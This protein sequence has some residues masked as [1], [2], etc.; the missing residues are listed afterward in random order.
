MTAL[1][2]GLFFA[3]PTSATHKLLHALLK[4]GKKGTAQAILLATLRLLQDAVPA[5]SAH[6][7]LRQAIQHVQPSFEFKR[8]KVG[9]LTQLIPGA[10]H[11]AQGEQVAIRWLLAAARQKQAKTR[12]LKVRLYRFEHFLA[13]ELLAAYSQQSE[14]LGKKLEAHKLAETNRA[15]AYQRWW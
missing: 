2:P 10:L 1:P 11:P 4:R 14:L 9:G 3:D 5:R 6:A 15:L 7:V 12:T 8:A 13:Q